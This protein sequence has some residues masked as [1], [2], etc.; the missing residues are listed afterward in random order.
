MFSHNC[1]RV[2]EL[3]T[4]TNIDKN[5]YNMGDLLETSTQIAVPLIS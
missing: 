2:A 3:L 1:I 5:N 4:S